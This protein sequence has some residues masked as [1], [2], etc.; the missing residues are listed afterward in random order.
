MCTTQTTILE[1][2]EQA[3]TFRL[4]LTLAESSLKVVLQDFVDWAIYSRTFF[5][6]VCMCE[7][8]DKKMSLRQV[9][10]AFAQTEIKDLIKLRRYK[11]GTVVKHKGHYA[12]KIERGGKLT[13]YLVNVDP[14]TKEEELNDSVLHLDKDRDMN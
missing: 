1:L 11:F 4:S 2:K 13:A 9:Y 10:D 5:G 12:F 14:N 7:N 3:D 6:D 8:P